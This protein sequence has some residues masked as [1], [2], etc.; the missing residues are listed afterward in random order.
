MLAQNEAP[1]LKAGKYRFD[2]FTAFRTRDSA[3]HT[4][5]ISRPVQ[6]SIGQ[7]H[8]FKKPIWKHTLAACFNQAK[9]TTS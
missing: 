1:I 2:N 6:L 3:V 8:I 5:K 4:H 9:R 7:P